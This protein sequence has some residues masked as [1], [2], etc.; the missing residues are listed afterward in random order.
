MGEREAGEGVGCGLRSRGAW[1]I[2][3]EYSCYQE[4]VEVM[5]ECESEQTADGGSDNR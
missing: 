1:F 5:D 2:S 4:G 3:S